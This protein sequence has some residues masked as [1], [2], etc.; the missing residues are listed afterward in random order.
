M[1]VDTLEQGK[2][3]GACGDC[4]RER[5]FGG[6]RKRVAPE[7][8][9]VRTKARPPKTPRPARTSPEDVQAVSDTIAEMAVG[10]GLRDFV[11]GKIILAPAR[12]G[13]SSPRASSARHRVYSKALLKAVRGRVADMSQPALAK[14]LTALGWRQCQTSIEMTHVTAWERAA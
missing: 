3:C 2:R 13:F 7:Q 6:A 14:C 8:T 10:A 1:Q 5:T 9:V 4:H 11:D 12:G